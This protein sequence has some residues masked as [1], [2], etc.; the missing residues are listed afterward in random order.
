MSHQTRDIYAFNLLR[1]S[2]LDISSDYSYLI[3]RLVD[4][5]SKQ[6][7]GKTSIIEFA[8]QVLKVYNSSNL[9]FD[10]DRVCLS[11]CSPLS[12]K[13]TIVSSA[14]TDDRGVADLTPGYHCYVAP[15]SSLFAE[16]YGDSNVGR[17]RVYSD[18]EGVIRSFIIRGKPVQRTIG[19]LAAAGFQSGLSLSLSMGDW[20]TGLLFLNS[21]KAG[22]FDNFK[23]PDYLSTCIL[24][25]VASAAIL[26][27]EFSPKAIDSQ[28]NATVAS[29][30]PVPNICV[31]LNFSD[32]L[33][34]AAM[35]R[36]GVQ[37]QVETQ[38]MLNQPFFYPSKTAI[39]VILKAME[40]LRFDD[41]GPICV[42]FAPAL[43]D[44][45]RLRIDFGTRQSRQLVRGYQ[46]VSSLA[47]SAG[48]ELTLNEDGL[49]LTTQYQCP[50]DLEMRV[51]YSVYE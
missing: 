19:K 6:S 23:D 38:T 1:S 39:L 21:K 47:E 18:I 20:G 36:F 5:E 2:K 25:M 46:S 15:Q 17:I 9:G 16:P 12:R 37:L 8:S 49:D 43:P 50:T 42:S 11:F 44:L 27:S 45:M 32:F 26:R 30:D 29:L 41:L 14:N 31:P 4:I 7:L 40:F 33:A 13:L 51:D 10:I 35:I 22:A 48:F 3:S 34:K 28:L 24:R